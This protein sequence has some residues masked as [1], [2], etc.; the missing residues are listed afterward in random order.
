MAKIYQIYEAT[1]PDPQARADQ[2]SID[3]IV[4]QIITGFGID[5]KKALTLQQIV[6]QIMFDDMRLN[7]TL[8]SNYTPEQKEYLKTRTWIEYQEAIRGNGDERD[9]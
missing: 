7:K 8:L 3:L 2:L 4:D 9:R 6:Y 1:T 5:A